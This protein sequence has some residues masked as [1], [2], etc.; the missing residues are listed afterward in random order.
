MGVCT[1]PLEK[2]LIIFRIGLMA[3]WELYWYCHCTEEEFPCLKGVIQTSGPNPCTN[4][5]VLTTSVVLVEDNRGAC[6]PRGPGLWKNILDIWN[7]RNH[8]RPPK[9]DEVLCRRPGVYSIP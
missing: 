8:L 1:D 5:A 7:L 9:F 6:F 2:V 4:T 3:R